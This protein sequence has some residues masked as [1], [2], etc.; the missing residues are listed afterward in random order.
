MPFLVKVLSYAVNLKRIVLFS[1]IQKARTIWSVKKDWEARFAYTKRVSTTNPQ[2]LYKEDQDKRSSTAADNI[3][4]RRETVIRGFFS[5]AKA[6][7]EVEAHAFQK[8][9]PANTTM[10][11]DLMS[12]FIHCV[13]SSSVDSPP[14]SF[15]CAQ[16]QRSITFI[17]F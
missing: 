2:S 8:S 11:Q 7:Q 9:L 14:P 16:K 13:S 17:S 15:Y 4:R 3:T 1:S 12:F 6:V 10:F 5:S